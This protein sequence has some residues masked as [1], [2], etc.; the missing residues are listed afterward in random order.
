ML[1]LKN[2][3][4]KWGGFG[5][6]ILP[7]M[8]IYALFMI[9][10]LLSGTFVMAFQEYEPI[11][12]IRK[13]VWLDNFKEIFTSD[14]FWTSFAV[15]IKYTICVVL[16]A[17]VLALLLAMLIES[18]A[19]K[20]LK[21]TFRNI[22]FIPYIVSGLIVGYLWK[23]MFT[24]VWPTLMEALGLTG[25]ASISW[26]GDYN[27]ALWGLIIQAVW[28]LMGFLIILYIAGLQAI[29]GE[30]IEASMLDGCSMV[31]Q[32][33]KVVIPMLMSTISVTLFLSIAEAFKQFDLA[34]VTMGGPG[35]ATSLL[36]YEIYKTAFLNK[37]Y[38]TSCAMALILMLIIG[39]VT[40][41]QMSITSRQEVNG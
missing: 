31:Q 17:N 38:G 9:Y 2:K 41:V 32:K 7:A 10:P 3:L 18:V 39:V 6:F 13:F 12:N 26:Y 11:R 21:A 23:F 35:S 24:A 14:E 40:V 19:G 16:I 5:V 36:S 34:F 15:T 20:F 4:V 33:F 37:S 27:M 28:K 1:N 8:I 29:P 30:V 22:F 25:L